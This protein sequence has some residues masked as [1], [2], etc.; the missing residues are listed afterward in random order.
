MRVAIME[1]LAP[2][3]D[4]LC[5]RLMTDHEVLLEAQGLAARPGPRQRIDRKIAAAI[6][7]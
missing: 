7:V 1:P 2:P 6:P 4:E 3:A 5:A